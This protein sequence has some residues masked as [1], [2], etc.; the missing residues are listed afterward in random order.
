MFVRFNCCYEE[1][2][3]A[4]ILAI[5]ITNLKMFEYVFADK[6]A[7]GGISFSSNKSVR[8]FLLVIKN[9]WFRLIHVT[10][11]YQ[12]NANMY[13]LQICCFCGLILGTIF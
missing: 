7:F 4:D 8:R 3:G 11:T 12:R 2:G 10:V 6:L 9:I 1:L 5:R 13:I